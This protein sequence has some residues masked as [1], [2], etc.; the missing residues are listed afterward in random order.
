MDY[1]IKRKPSEIVQFEFC[2]FRERI[3][4]ICPFVWLCSKNIACHSED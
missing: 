1:S 4:F 2:A 3:A